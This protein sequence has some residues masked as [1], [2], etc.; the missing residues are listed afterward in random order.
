MAETTSDLE[1][2]IGEKVTLKPSP[3][4]PNRRSFITMLVLGFSIVSNY[5]HS[6][7]SL[8]EETPEQPYQR[9][10]V[11]FDNFNG[12][13]V[14]DAI[15]NYEFE[16]SNQDGT[17]KNVSLGNAQDQLFRNLI[18]VLGKKRA[19][20]IAPVFVNASYDGGL[21]Y[22]RRVKEYQ[23]AFQN[24]GTRLSDLI[25]HGSMHV[26][27]VYM[28]TH[29]ELLRFA[30]FYG[31]D[32]LRALYEGNEEVIKQMQPPAVAG[33]YSQ[34]IKPFPSK[35][36]LA[37]LGEVDFWKAVGLEWPEQRLDFLLNLCRDNAMGSQWLYE[38]KNPYEGIKY[39]D[40]SKE[41][42]K[43]LRNLIE[44]RRTL[45]GAN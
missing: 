40:D 42:R 23:S 25:S 10:E 17:T 29:A 21:R 33:Y 16:V 36:K 43:L 45:V 22:H 9:F 34:K 7:I 44:N 31:K 30:E 5:A 24:G 39:Y 35:E 41:D 2:R 38:E 13:D 3:T 4:H 27:D 1:M 37:K 26:A 6:K 15:W 11:S 32:T 18:K 12:Q 20:E 14:Y 19:N 28:T 8:A